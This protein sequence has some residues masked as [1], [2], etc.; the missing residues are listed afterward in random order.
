MFACIR[1]TVFVLA[2]LTLLGSCYR[3]QPPAQAEAKQD[4]TVVDC[5]IELVDMSGVPIELTPDKPPELT[6]EQKLDLARERVQNIQKAVKSYYIHHDSLPTTL[7]QLAEPRNGVPAFIS[8]IDEFVDPWG[9]TYR[10]QL[11]E[12]GNGHVEPAVWTMSPD[13]I[14]VGDAPKCP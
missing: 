13:L 8:D 7:E 6:D 1:N 11:R 12:A 5:P 10:Y 9:Q 14:P 3:P 2:M 4:E